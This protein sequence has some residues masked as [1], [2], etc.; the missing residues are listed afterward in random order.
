MEETGDEPKE[1]SGADERLDQIDPSVLEN[2]GNSQERK[3]VE[4]PLSP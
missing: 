3:G 2:I 1:G 4:S